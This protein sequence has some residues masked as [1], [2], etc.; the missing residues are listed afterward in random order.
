MTIET[1]EIRLVFDF[2]RYIGLNTNK[3]IHLQG[4]LLLKAILVSKL[5]FY[6][7]TG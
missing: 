6:F 2:Y 7:F 4:Y 1:L 3:S 5:H